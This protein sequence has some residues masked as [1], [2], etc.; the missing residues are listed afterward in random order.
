[1]RVV[2]I[3]TGRMGIAQ[4]R[5]ARFNGD[6]IAFGIDVNSNAQG[7]FETIFHLKCFTSVSEACWD[8]IDLVWVTVGDDQ[9]EDMAQQLSKYIA[10]SCIVLHTSG[11][12]TS[13]SLRR[14]LPNHPCASMHP[15]MS[16]PLT[17]VSDLECFNTYKGVLHTLEGD[18]PAIKCAEMLVERL[19]GRAVRISEAQKPL[20][21]AAA[22]FAS[23]YPIVLLN[24]A[25]GIFEECG[26]S[27]HDALAGAR[28]LFWQGAQTCQTVEP[29]DALTGPVKRRD[30]NTIAKHLDVLVDNKSLYELYM[31]MLTAAQSMVGWEDLIHSHHNFD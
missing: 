19:G 23:N 30:L 3:G 18:E 20:Y 17:S 27:H 25:V 1:M 5:L 31:A 12:H 26:F 8:D 6:T 16:C 28:R 29:L 2:I 24:V 10:A 11:L 22:V 15:L 14:Y 13:Q 21:H 9:I 4:A 7:E